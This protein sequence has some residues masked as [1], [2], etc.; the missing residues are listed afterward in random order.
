MKIWSSKGFLNSHMQTPKHITCEKYGDV[1]VF[2]C[3]CVCDFKICK[4]SARNE[5]ECVFL[6]DGVCVRD[7]VSESV[8][9]RDRE[10]VCVC[11]C[12]FDCV[13]F[14]VCMCVH[15]CERETKRVGVFGV[16]VG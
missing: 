9:K 15:V 11:V 10:S 16:R 14:W 7:C 13:C 2:V 4:Y 3:V 5:S 1:S 8:L 12:V 6:R